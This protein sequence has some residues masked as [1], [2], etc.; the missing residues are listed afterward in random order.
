MTYP[1]PNIMRGHSTPL[2]HNDETISQDF[3]RN[4]HS[5]LEA[6]TTAGKNRILL[7]LQHEIAAQLEAL[8]NETSE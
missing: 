4:M 5:L 8:E 6:R 1:V 7:R 3:W 2:L